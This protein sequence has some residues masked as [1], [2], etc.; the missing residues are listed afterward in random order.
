VTHRRLDHHRGGSGEPLLLLHGVGHT[1]R[2]WRGLLPE[3][4]RGFEVLAPDLPGFGGSDPLPAET[5]PTPGALADVVERD[6]DAVGWQAP[7][8]AGNSLGGQIALELG[9]RGRARTVVAISPAGMWT[10][11]ENLWGQA[12]LE[13]TRA[14]SYVP[15]P[16][17]AL[18][19]LPVRVAVA[20]VLLGRPWR[21]SP[22][23]LA[24]DARLLRR[25]TAYRQTRREV[26]RR[27]PEGLEDIRCPV[28]IAWGTRDR[29][30]LPRQAQRWVAAIPGA[31]LRWLKAL[32][33]LPMLEEP[34]LVARMIRDF[35]TKRPTS[36][37]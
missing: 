27:R 33:H 16:D 5:A 14:L 26:H 6:L 1:R 17:L 10:R 8:V 23:Q 11:R 4:E 3:L 30:T 13:A 22:D 12:V 37:R 20:G 31:E 29:L 21:A 34:E 24:E 35:A 32:G 9:R 25:S 15:R 2:A 36:D 18:R 7:H 19:L 28:L